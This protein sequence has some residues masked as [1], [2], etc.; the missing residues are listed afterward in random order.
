MPRYVRMNMVAVILLDI[1][2]HYTNLLRYTKR[3]FRPYDMGTS[4][5][6]TLKSDNCTLTW[7]AKIEVSS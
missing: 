1:I 7:K 5:A 6:G 3:Y 4:D 2:N